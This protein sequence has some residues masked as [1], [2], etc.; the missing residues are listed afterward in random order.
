MYPSGV[1]AEG[2]RGGHGARWWMSRGE[3]RGETSG[4]M[5]CLLQEGLLLL[6]GG[7]L[8]RPLLRLLRAELLLRDA[9]GLGQAAARADVGGKGEGDGGAVR[10]RCWEGSQG[11]ARR[12]G[13]AEMRAHMWCS[14]AS[15]LSWMLRWTMMVLN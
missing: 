1:R 8:L 12:V 9:G 3:R 7:E 6:L 10:G 4:G 15:L 11:G 14:S 5:L 13:R 2:I